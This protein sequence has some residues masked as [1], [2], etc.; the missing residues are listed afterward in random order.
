MNYSPN[1]HRRRSI[2]LKEY[3][4]SQAGMYFMTICAHKRACLFGEIEKDAMVL[5]DAGKIVRAT[6]NNLPE[7]Y[8][9]VALDELVIMPNHLHGIVVFDALVG[10]AP[11]RHGLSEIV[12][13]FKTFSS[14]RINEIRGTR[15]AS[16]WQRNYWERVIRNES[17]LA[18]IREYIQNNPRQWELDK[19]HPQFQGT[20]PEDFTVR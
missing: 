1:I 11:A 20:Q 10:P 17:E 9:H 3:D 14:R 12:R 7:H 5:N 19:L 4:Y 16:V 18:H 15:G 13:A 6:W 8:A 2:R